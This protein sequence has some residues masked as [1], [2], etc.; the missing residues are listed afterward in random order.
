VREPLLVLDAGLRIKSA[1]DSFY[2]MFEVIPEEALNRLVYEPGNREWDI[3]KLRRLSGELLPEKK[4]MS[5]YEMT[6]DL[7]SIGRK[8]MLLNAPCNRERH[9]THP[10]GH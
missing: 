1:S 9:T 3:P 7:A 6:L 2:K 8:T 4:S 10:V 5:D